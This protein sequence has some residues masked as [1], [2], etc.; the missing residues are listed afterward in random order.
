MPCSTRM[1]REA[2]ALR[3]RSFGVGDLGVVSDDACEGLVTG[4]CGGAERPVLC[5]FLLAAG[6]EFSIAVG[7]DA[8]PLTGDAPSG[9]MV[10]GGRRPVAR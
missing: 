6:A 8:E 10:N 5:G 3:C 1:R 9:H 4:A 2:Y 7:S